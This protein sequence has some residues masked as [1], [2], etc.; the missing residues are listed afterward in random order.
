[1]KFIL[2]DIV[3][4][5]TRSS[6][7]VMVEHLPACFTVFSECCYWDGQSSPFYDME[8]YGADVKQGKW[9]VDSMEIAFL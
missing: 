3:V 2:L 1:M 6:V 7:H 5:Q 4:P 8:K 9:S